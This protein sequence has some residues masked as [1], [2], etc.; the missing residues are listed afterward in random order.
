MSLLR[1]IRNVRQ[2]AGEPRR[3][4]FGCEDLDLIVWYDE[5]GE[6]SS[7]QLCYDKLRSERALT[8][9]PAA[10]LQHMAVDDGEGPGL[11]HKASP[12]LVEDGYFDAKRIGERFAQAAA[13][14]PAEIVE[15]VA[16]KLRHHPSAAP[17]S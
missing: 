17:R 5:S 9:E 12:I 11:R 13:G 1:E 15:F 6:L 2:I 4:W 7:F 10:G 14:L 3:R 8:W 16:A